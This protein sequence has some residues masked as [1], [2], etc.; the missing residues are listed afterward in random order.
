MPVKGAE[1][2]EQWRARA[3]NYPTGLAYAMLRENLPFDGFWYAEEMLAARDD[4]LSLYDIFVR[5]ERQVIHA[6]LG[7]NRL[8]LPTPSGMKWM[9]EMI[10]AMAF[11]PVDLSTLLKE[12]FHSEPTAAVRSLKGV[13]DETLALVEQKLP[14]F[15]TAPYRANQLRQRPVWD[16]PLRTRPT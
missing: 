12:A 5:V 14:E 11:K 10:A 1:L 9:D 16:N 13:I 3:A 2:V 15:D 4:L 6:L 8:Y 7:L